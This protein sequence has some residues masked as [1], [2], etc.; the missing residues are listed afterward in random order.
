VVFLLGG[1]TDKLLSANDIAMTG[2]T[3]QRKDSRN[4]KGFPTQVNYI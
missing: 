4:E 3:G 2:T 1:G